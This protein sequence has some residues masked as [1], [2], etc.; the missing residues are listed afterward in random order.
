MN[1][2]YFRNRR[3][4]LACYLAHTMRDRDIPLQEIAEELRVCPR[5]AS[6]YLNAPRPE[7]PPWNETRPSLDS[8][9]SDGLCGTRPDLDFYTE[10]D[11]EIAEAKA[12]C[13]DCPV[14]QQC[15]DYSLAPQAD[16]W[17]VWAAMTR[18]ERRDIQHG[19]RIA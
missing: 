12:V 9:H 7:R 10:D 19:Q 13:R 18:Q 17:G 14:L 16:E 2:S 8:F 5:T 3:R 15:R 1:A 11:A 6:R 4:V